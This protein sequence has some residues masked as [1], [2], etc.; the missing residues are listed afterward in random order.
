M[1][2]KAR[3]NRTP[4]SF[5][6]QHRMNIHRLRHISG[7][8]S[9]LQNAPKEHRLKPKSLS[10]CRH[11]RRLNPETENLAGYVRREIKA[12]IKTLIMKNEPNFR[13]TAAYINSY[14]KRNCEY[15]QRLDHH[16][17]KPNRTR[18][19]T[20]K[21]LLCYHLPVDIKT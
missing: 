2:V 9:Y 10:N 21:I 17:N 19:R 4:R 1:A 15:I 14:K 20:G 12:Q 7:I 6:K 5:P 3:T 11:R 13:N 16:K 8:T 18:S